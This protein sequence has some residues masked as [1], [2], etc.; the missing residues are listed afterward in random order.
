MPHTAIDISKY[1][2]SKTN[3]EE[4][5]ELLSNMK[6]QKLLYYCQ[7]FYYAKFGEKLFEDNIYAW[8]Y[9]PVVKDVYHNFKYFGS[10]GIPLDVV[11][12]V[13]TLNENEKKMVDEVFTY[14]NQFSAIK[15]MNMTHSEEP[16]IST[17]MTNEITLDK[18]KNHFEQFLTA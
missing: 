17:Q 9:G 13:V 4:G 11:D 2:I 1:L 15:L 3:P 8:Q 14:F 10:N 7:G 12:E 5:G 6:L 18:L 16:W